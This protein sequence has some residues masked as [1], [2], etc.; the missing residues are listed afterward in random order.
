[1]GAALALEDLPNR[2]RMMYSNTRYQTPLIILG[3]IKYPENK[4]YGIEERQ[5]QNRIVRYLGKRPDPTN[6]FANVIVEREDGTSWRI[7]LSRFEDYEIIDRVY[8]REED[9]DD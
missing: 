9:D 2:F 7:R 3:K 5:V 6:P 1:M 4:N 8:R